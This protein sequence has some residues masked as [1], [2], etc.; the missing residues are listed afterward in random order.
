MGIYGYINRR[1]HHILAKSFRGLTQRCGYRVPVLMTNDHQL[2]GQV[3]IKEIWKMTSM[4][5]LGY[6]I[7]INASC[8]FPF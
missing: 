2:K 8:L 7:S 6:A 1:V 4:G 5:Y 3:E